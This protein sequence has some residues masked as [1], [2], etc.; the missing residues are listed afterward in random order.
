MDG[1]GEIIREHGPAAFA[2]AWR[3]L[4]DAAHAEAAAEEIFRQAREAGMPPEGRRCCWGTLFRRLAVRCA[5]ARL[6]EHAALRRRPDPAG[7]LRAALA[8]L[9]G[10]EAAAFALRYFEDL[11]TEQ[12]AGTLRLGEAA[13]ILA[14]SR[15]RVR[16]D[17][18]LRET[19]EQRADAPP[20]AA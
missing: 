4:G 11:P 8:R 20:G 5:L 7:R 9:P 17:S 10:D 6:Q 18:M 16:L 3:I 12:I 15:A 1:W 13:V 19:V 14:L 2:A